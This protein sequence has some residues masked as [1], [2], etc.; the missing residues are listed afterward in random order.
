[1]SPLDD[2]LWDYQ[3]SDGS[4]AEL[5]RKLEDADLAAKLI[6]SPADIPRRAPAPIP[7]T[8]PGS[9]ALNKSLAA[10]ATIF[11][12]QAAKPSAAKLPASDTATR[13]NSAKH[14]TA[15]RRI[16]NRA[17][18]ADVFA[19]IKDADFDYAWDKLVQSCVDHVC[20]A[21]HEVAEEAA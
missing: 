17:R 14:E 12:K 8:A 3:R 10:L 1:M 13:W 19:P 21:V 11:A 9:S 18:S 5:C 20:S 16:V 6:G 2:P 4:G 15:M 7:A